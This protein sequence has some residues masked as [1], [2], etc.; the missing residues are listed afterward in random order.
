MGHY[1][2]CKKVTYKAEDEHL[3]PKEGQDTA[4]LPSSAAAKPTGPK[5]TSAATSSPGAPLRPPGMP[6]MM[7]VNASNPSL[8]KANDRE[9]MLVAKTRLE[10]TLDNLKERVAATEAAIQSADKALEKAPQSTL[11]SAAS[12]RQTASSG[13]SAPATVTQLATGLCASQAQAIGM[14]ENKKQ[15]PV[16]SQPA[17]SKSIMR[18]ASDN[19]PI[20]HGA[21][22]T[23]VIVV[24]VPWKA[25]ESAT[26]KLPG[27]ER[28]IGGEPLHTWW[29]R[30]YKTGTLFAVELA[31]HQDAEKACHWLNCAAKARV[32]GEV[33][34]DSTKK[35]ENS[36]FAFVILTPH[37]SDHFRR[38]VNL[39]AAFEKCLRRL[40]GTKH[41]NEPT[42]TP[43][44][45][46]SSE[47]SNSWG[48]KYP[49]C[50]PAPPEV[51]ASRPPA[52]PW[53]PAEVCGP[54]SQGYT[55]TFT[56]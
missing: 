41:Y 46:S 20:Q 30:S 7:P 5:A 35:D 43:E 50:P 6:P 9:R 51:C 55:F 10:K 17:S 37:D 49:N 19:A 45:A 3:Y 16:A 54:P 28:L 26:I 33:V 52:P 14:N 27:M 8:P 1:K 29:L 42:K 23:Y 53:V 24:R 13:S 12:L 32:D 25:T 22:G 11:K 44:S 39:V 38:N 4:L 48:V 21:W 31:A 40:E 15:V 34:G 18:P 47:A 36:L 56:P 2:C